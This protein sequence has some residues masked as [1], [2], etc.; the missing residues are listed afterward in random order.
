MLFCASLLP[1][2]A[3]AKTNHHMNPVKI[4]NNTVEKWF[5]A[6]R[7]NKYSGLTGREG[8]NLE[9]SVL[10]R[11]GATQPPSRCTD[12]RYFP[13]LLARDDSEM[14]LTTTKDGVQLEG[15]IKGLC[16][17][18]FCE[19]LR[20]AEC[21]DAILRKAHVK[22]MDMGREGKNMLIHH[23][24]LILYDFDIA[25][26]DG[27]KLNTTFCSF[28]V[29]SWEQPVLEHPARCEHLR[30]QMPSEPSGPAGP[31]GSAGPE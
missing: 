12:A 20:Q 13:T 17:I 22:H 14:K 1:A 9:V 29:L 15:H 31:T 30:G 18:P 19:A 7:L 11:L 16:M 5:D 23:G 26:I 10:E 21:M 8:Y 27:V 25:E 2:L 28:T 6:T 3:V 24:R 4:N